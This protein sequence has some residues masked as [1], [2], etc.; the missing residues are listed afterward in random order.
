MTLTLC[1]WLWLDYVMS[2]VYDSMIW[3][4]SLSLS[5]TLWLYD[6]LT[7]NVGHAGSR[8]QVLKKTSNT[9][10]KALREQRDW[11]TYITYIFIYSY[12]Q[13]FFL[14]LAIYALL[15]LLNWDRDSS[16][17]LAVLGSVEGPLTIDIAKEQ[18]SRWSDGLVTDRRYITSM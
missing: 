10:V 3:Y 5:M 13:Q 7:D 18:A 2:H 11:E 8:M 9:L 1:L 16:F 6:S 12:I 4:V 15:L 17:R 14:F